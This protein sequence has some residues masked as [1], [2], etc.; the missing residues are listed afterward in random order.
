MNL[1]AMKKT[2]IARVLSLVSDGSLD[3]IRE[4]IETFISEPE[5][6][7]QTDRSLQ[8]IWKNKGFENIA[9]LDAELKAVRREMGNS[10]LRRKF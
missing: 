6:A 3:K 4:Y 2:E 8:G 10:I 7:R 5:T 9:D 1:S